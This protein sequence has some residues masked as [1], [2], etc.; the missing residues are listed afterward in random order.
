[1]RSRYQRPEVPT[2]GLV[3]Q[4]RDH[5][6]VA[7]V[8]LHRTLR[9]RHVASLFFEGGSLRAAQARLRR[10]WEWGYL[11]RIYLPFQVDGSRRPPTE[12][13]APAYVLGR[14]GRGLHQDRPG[15]AQDEPVG[16]PT[17]EHRLVVSEFLVSL[18]LACR[19]LAGAPTLASFSPEGP[20]WRSLAEAGR[21]RA[22]A[23]VPDAT[24]VL[25]FPPPH[26][27]LRFYVEVVRA[28]VRGGNQ[29]LRE[30][31]RRYVELN[32]SGGLRQLYNHHEA[33]RAVLFIAPTETR[34]ANLRAIAGRLVHGRRLF[35]F[36][37]YQGPNAGD[38][39]VWRLTPDQLLSLPWTAADG[40][41]FT[42][43]E[44]ESPSPCL[45]PSPNATRQA[46]S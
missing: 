22:G 41:R 34:A 42:L 23:L 28:D 7:A 24:F 14:H 35:W 6:I 3:L 29:R 12:A 18:Q 19:G 27:E 26:Q 40:T 2:R 37:S 43:C 8:A 17:L 25:C 39:V 20:L 30:K 46:N 13:G 38:Q 45:E 36:S 5:A 11:D 9:A 21:P 15:V 16:I 31:M 4:A 44:P 33:L 1:M 32:R 10:L